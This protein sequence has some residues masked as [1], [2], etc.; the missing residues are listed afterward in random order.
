MHF[1]FH[2]RRESTAVGKD[3]TPEM[4]EYIIDMVHPDY[5]QCDCKGHMGY[6]SYPTKVGYRAPG[7]ARDTLTIWR[8]VTARRGVALFLH[9]S[10]I[11]DDMAIKHH[12]DWARVDEQ[13]HE[14]VHMVSAFGPYVDELMIPQLKE[15]NDR[16][17]VDGVWVDGDCWAVHHDYRAEVIAA[18]QDQTGIQE[19]PHAPTD[20][21]Y[22]EFTQFCREGFRTYLRHYIDTLHQHNADFQIASNWA[23]SSKMP[24]PVSADV[25]FLSGDFW[26]QNSVNSARLEARCLRHQGLPWDLMA[27]SFGG[28]HVL[29][30]NEEDFS[31]K[32]VSQLQR[33]AAIVLA[34][35]GG[36]QLYFQQ[37]RNGAIFPWQMQV[38][39]EV[40]QFCRA[41]QD[42][43]HH[44][45]PI[46]QIALYYAGSTFYHQATALFEA[47]D[48]ALQPLQG[49]L[50]ILLD[51]QYSTDILMEH[52][53]KGHMAEY[54]IIVVP[55][56]S[57]LEP[58]QIENL[59]AYA[60]NGGKLLLIGPA[61][62]FLFA[63]ALQVDFLDVSHDQQAIYLEYEGSLARMKT[64]TAQV[65]LQEPAQAFGC[66]YASNNMTL[67]S[68]TAASI[69]AYGRGKIAATYFNVG[70]RYLEATTTV[71]RDFIQALVHELF[72][73]PLVTVTGSH[74]VDV[75]LN[76]FGSKLAINL[77]NTAGPHADIHVHVFDEIP[78]V[79]PLTISI[80]C[81]EQPS[82][83]MCQPE[84]FALP[85]TWSEGRAMVTLPRLDIH[86]VLIVE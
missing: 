76:R 6:S 83:I 18:F 78:A 17:S 7:I 61:T 14:D 24:E 25:D 2:A 68:T 23:F 45:E 52:Q 42:V 57:Q 81:E 29:G 66:W 54:P 33:E 1:D 36:F 67:P 65:Q 58:D 9:Y 86:V 8:E 49:V 19:I 46:P 21:Y 85:F 44:A 40:A 26:L 62:A 63:T 16:Y 30:D 4:V 77:V 84:N 48:G 74:L 34:L 22:Y 82:R 20:A 5:I 47:H 79:G 56:W 15:L 39:R 43:C 28:Q 27:W 38:A 32:S 35:S 50:Q 11:W 55:E 41:R 71:V 70:K 51:N 37:D 13:G 59:L 31:T 10:G 72:P 12:P 60:H 73:E 53:L 75:A 3:V 64:A 69:T 80:R